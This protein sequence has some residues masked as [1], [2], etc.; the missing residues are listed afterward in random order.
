MD[1][2]YINQNDIHEQ[3]LL[4][5]L[6]KDE[7]SEYLQHI[8]TCDSCKF[9]LESERQTLQSIRHFGKS[10]MKSEI[11]RKVAELKTKENQISWDMILKVP[12]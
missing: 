5:R 12:K 4:K 1:C 10:E 11:A 7:N 6:N 2:K 8:E 9:K 3:Y